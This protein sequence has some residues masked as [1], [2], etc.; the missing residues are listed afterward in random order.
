MRYPVKNSRP[1]SGCR[2]VQRDPRRVTFLLQE[3]GEHERAVL[4][5][6]HDENSNRCR[7][8]DADPLVIGPCTILSSGADSTLGRRT[9][10]RCLAQ[11]RRSERPR[12]LCDAQSHFG[13]PRVRDQ[14]LPA[15][16]R[17][18]GIP[19]RRGRIRARGRQARDANARI[20]HTRRTTKPISSLPRSEIRPRGGEYF[21]A[22]ARTFEITCSTASDPLS[23]PTRL[24]A[25]PV[26]SH[27]NAVRGGG[28]SSPSPRAIYF[29]GLEE[30]RG[31]D[32]GLRTRCQGR[33]FP[34]LPDLTKSRC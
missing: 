9:V 4:A 28:C 11:P 34:A 31:G 15:N 2:D 20:T 32:S 25:H 21:A 30:L 3:F 26:S 29:R 12:C 5:V 18:L 16:G 13:Q 23:Q 17:R 1:A 14:R 33:S 7:V 27:V 8:S 22:F 24:V 6:N 19:G 10:I